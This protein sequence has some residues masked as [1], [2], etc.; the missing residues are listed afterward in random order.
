MEVGKLIV[1]PGGYRAF[2]PSKIPI[3][4]PFPM[5]GELIRLLN[6]ASLSLGKLDGITQILPDLDFFIFMYVRKE[7][8][9]STEI[10][11]TRATMINSIEAELKL[12]PDLPDDVDDILH[13]IKA[14]NHGLNRLASL[15]LSLRL[16]REV[17]KVLM[18]GARSTHPSTPG[19]FR[20]SQNWIGGT[21]PGTARFV[22]PPV[23]EMNKALGDFEIFLK[24]EKD[25]PPLIKTGVIHSQ[26]EAIHPF[27]DGNGRA[28]RLLITFYLCEQKILEKPVLYLSEFFKK[29]RD[30]YFDLLHNYH[31]K[32]DVLPWLRFFLEGVNEVAKKAI[33]TS[34][35][36]NLLRKEDVEKVQKMARSSEAMYKVL[37][38]LYELPIVNVKT[39]RRWTGLA[40]SSA[41]ELVE[42]L[43]KIKILQQRDRGS[44]YARVFEYKKYLDLFVVD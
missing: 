11:G 28:G 36:I 32:G 30:L 18:T 24:K 44:H 19:E 42:R 41:N 15:P 13:Y 37:D 34:R 3:P 16:M 7:A 1:Q 43:V 20:E 27:L 35:K 10:E 8:A 29:N 6:D 40:R 17:H 2:I 31:N 23:H 26:F 21:S 14:M 38:K 22:P 4:W 39:V 25:I 5:D 33:E 9:L 12:K